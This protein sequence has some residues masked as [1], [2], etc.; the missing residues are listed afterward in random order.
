MNYKNLIDF[1]INGNEII[2]FIFKNNYK[3]NFY[4]HIIISFQFK[5][6]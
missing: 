1:Y 4:I 5:K 2:L 3:I 6:D